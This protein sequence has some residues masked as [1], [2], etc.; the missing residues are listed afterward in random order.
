[1]IV[2]KQK[3]YLP[4]Q[5]EVVDFLKV[6]CDAQCDRLV[7]LVKKLLQFGSVYATNCSFKAYTKFKKLTN[8]C[9][10]YIS[11]ID[12]ATP[13]DYFLMTGER[14]RIPKKVYSLFKHSLMSSIGAKRVQNALSNNYSVYAYYKTH[15]VQDPYYVS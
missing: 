3:D 5:A 1:M 15:V 2:L 11:I 13:A 6:K 12:D 4:V 9:N 8:T 7:Y 14:K 10:L